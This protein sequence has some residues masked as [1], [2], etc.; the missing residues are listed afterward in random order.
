MKKI[1]I[2]SA[3][4]FSILLFSCGGKDSSKK[5]GLETEKQ[6]VVADCNCSEI[7]FNGGQAKNITKKGSKELFSGTCLEKDVHDSI[8]RK[9][10]VDKG[11]IVEKLYRKKCKNGYITTLNYKY[12]NG[13]KLD[14]Y[15]LQIEEKEKSNSNKY[16]YV[17][18][19]EEIKNGDVYNKW[20]A[21]VTNWEVNGASD[22]ISV[23]GKWEVKQGEKVGSENTNDIK[24]KPKC[25]NDNAK[26]I[27]PDFNWIQEDL[28]LVQ[29]SKILNDLKGEFPHF[30]YWDL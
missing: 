9:V 3:V 12:R 14:G 6:E 8:I 16:G 22:V 30:N 25:F 23:T 2:L 21:F 19:Y 26:K 13:E 7:E 29:Q 10:I 18:F 24:D 17:Q 27:F 15:E 5:D 28:S 4:M 1:K 20:S 11:F